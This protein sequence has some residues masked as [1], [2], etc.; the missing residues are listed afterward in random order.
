MTSKDKVFET[1]KKC[2]SP[3]H[4]SYLALMTY[5]D[6]PEESM[7]R[8]RVAV[9]RLVSEGRVNRVSRGVYELNKEA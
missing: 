2:D 6:A 8:V 3:S 7:N 1:I 9:H 4:I 5:P